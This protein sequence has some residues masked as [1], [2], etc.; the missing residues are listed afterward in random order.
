MNGGNILHQRLPS[1][2]GATVPAGTAISKRPTSRDRVRFSKLSSHAASTASRAAAPNTNCPRSSRKGTSCRSAGP[3]PASGSLSRVPTY[4]I[5]ARTRPGPPAPLT[6]FT[7]AGWA[8]SATAAAPAPDPS[9]GLRTQRCA[10]SCDDAG[11]VLPH[12]HRRSLPRRHSRPPQAMTGA[13]CTFRSG[14]HP[15]NKVL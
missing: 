1:R 6:I 10:D 13:N 5:R 8:P 9:L 11:G 3:F 12:F 2:S 14:M 15:R 4:V 7:T